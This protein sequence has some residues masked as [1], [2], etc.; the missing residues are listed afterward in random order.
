MLKQS[1]FFNKLISKKL[2]ASQY[3]ILYKLHNSLHLSELGKQMIR[4]KIP[5]IYINHDCTLTPKGEQLIKSFE[6]LFKPIKK[7]KNIELLG[8][9]FKDKIIEFLD[10]FP[11]HKLPSGKYAKG[12]KKNIEDN[13][14]WF[15]QEYEYDWDT[16]LKATEM[17][18]EEYRL[19]NYMYMRTAMYFIKK[20][21][22]GTSSSELA[23]YCDILNSDDDYAPERKIKTR[24]V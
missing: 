20:L 5:K 18:V 14:M 23:N 10:L 9:D 6:I 2:T 17:Y 12:N 16:I 1:A 22:D 24:V 21:V 8:P 4:D 19:K 13:F 7:L 11:T 3:E 15:F